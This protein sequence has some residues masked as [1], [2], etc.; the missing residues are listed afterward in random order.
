VNHYRKKL[1]RLSTIILSLSFVIL[2]GCGE[3]NLLDTEGYDLDLITLISNPI[4]PQP[5]DTTTLSVRISGY[6]SGAWPSYFWEVNAGSLLVSNEAV[7]EWIV[8]EQLGDYIVKAKSSLGDVSDACSLVVSVRN[9]EQIDTGKR[10]NLYPNLIDG[11]LFFVSSYGGIYFNNSDY[12]SANVVRY[13]SPGVNESITAL[14]L[15]FRAGTSYGGDNFVFTEDGQ[16]VVASV[17]TSSNP[18]AKVPRKNVAKYELSG[19][20]G[21]I[22]TDQYNDTQIDRCDQYRYPFPN[23]AATMVVMQKLEMGGADNGTEDLLNISFWNQS[24]GAPIPLT[25][26]MISIPL[27]NDSGDTLGWREEYF[28]NTKPIFT[29]DEAYIIYFCDS[30]GTFEPSM[31]PISGEQPVISALMVFDLFSDLGI[32]MPPDPVLQ[33]EP[34]GGNRLAFIADV[35]YEKTLCFLEYN[36]G[37][38]SSSSLSALKTNVTGI[39]EFV[40]ATDG[41]GRGAVITGEGIYIVGSGGEIQTEVMAKERSTDM[42]CGVN[43]SPDCSK[44][45]FRIGR[46]GIEWDEAFSA[47]MVYSLDADWATATYVTKG[48]PWPTKQE[49]SEEDFD[50]RWRR[51]IFESDNEGL[52]GP[53]TIGEPGTGEGDNPVSVSIKIVH[54]WK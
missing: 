6:S 45:G 51:V 43:W 36:P 3:E 18:F 11:N 21:E 17:I 2:T 7:V 23:S 30:S 31:I 24:V 20:G 53:V 42:I 12:I 4:C 47:L 49:I 41:S 22:V 27:T 8:P 10:Y 16:Q 28:E 33:W 38:L 25:N 50:F 1:L 44:I 32:N 29:P 13:I 15:G 35:N 37:S 48:Y 39:S 52:Y 9:Y 34:D 5:G 19:S 40:W 46:M 54:S 14:D 26:S